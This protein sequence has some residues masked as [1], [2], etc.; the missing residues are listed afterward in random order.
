MAPSRRNPTRV[1]ITRSIYK[2][3][4]E[5]NE[6]TNSSGKE[7]ADSATSNTDEEE[8]YHDKE[9]IR[10]T[11][12]DDVVCSTPRGKKYMIP[13]ISTCP[14]APKKRRLVL[15][16][17]RAATKFFSHPDLDVFFL[18]SSPPPNSSIHTLD[19]NQAR[20]FWNTRKR[21]KR[22]EMRKKGYTTFDSLLVSVW[23][24]TYLKYRAER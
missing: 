3:Q 14:P 5:A 17:S 19:S 23:L 8:G 12:E 2:K 24:I 4:Q 22:K 15:N 16:Q 11:C 7:E 20:L 10:S 13:K 1:I 9:I 18:F 21:K 6:L